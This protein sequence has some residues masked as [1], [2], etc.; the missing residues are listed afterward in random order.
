MEISRDH[1]CKTRNFLYYEYFSKHQKLIA[2]DISTQ[3]ERENLNTSQ[4]I[5]FTGNLGNFFVIRKSQ[6]TVLHVL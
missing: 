2:V 4:Q 1:D 5:N 3:K 6:E